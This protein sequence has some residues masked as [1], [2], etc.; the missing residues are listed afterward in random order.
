MFK[1]IKQ[2]IKR[3]YRWWNSLPN[4][5]QVQAPHHR[6]TVSWRVCER[7]SSVQFKETLKDPDS[8]KGI[9]KPFAKLVQ[10]GVFLIDSWT[11]Q[12]N[13]EAYHSRWF[14]LKGESKEFLSY[15][16]ADKY[17]KSNFKDYYLQSV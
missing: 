16:E 14:N 9:R 10:F 15:E 4:F 17:G 2:Q 11:G 8:F 13:M 1:T 3:L 7:L 6:E 12:R 5:Y